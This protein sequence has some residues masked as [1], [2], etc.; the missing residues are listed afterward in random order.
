MSATSIGNKGISIVEILIVIG[1][2]VIGLVGFFTVVVF[3]LRASILVKETVS[4]NNM[5][6]EAMEAVRNFRDGTEWDTDG[7]ALLSTSLGVSYHPELDAGNPP[8]WI[9]VEGLE[10]IGD[11][12]R[13]II[14]EK[15]SRNPV[16][17]DIEEV[18][19]SNNDDPN[20]RKASVIISW[21]TKE[22]KVVTYFTNWNQ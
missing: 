1:L 19:N 7:I 13:E 9:L 5:A 6:Q 22:V 8:A 4:A 10:S 21:R 18:Y 12:S 2:I 3:S 20:T 11:F 16:S 17:G 15:V 14:F